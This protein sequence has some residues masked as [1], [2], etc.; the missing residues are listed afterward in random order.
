MCA[1][2]CA[3]PTLGHR[4]LS[5]FLA[6]RPCAYQDRTLGV[7][8]LLSSLTLIAW[9]IRLQFQKHGRQITLINR[10]KIAR[11]LQGEDNEDARSRSRSS[12]MQ[13]AS[14]M[15]D[16]ERRHT[17]RQ[18]SDLESSLKRAE[19]QEHTHTENDEL[20]DKRDFQEMWAESTETQHA[21]VGMIFDWFKH[22]LTLPA[23]LWFTLCLY[24][25]SLCSS[26][27]P[28]HVCSL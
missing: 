12:S 10:L 26:G 6:Y 24:L 25:H 20:F 9:A 19:E 4:I 3:V 8:L 17:F 13:R 14:I 15:L 11:D 27:Q 1:G 2:V 16:A 18:K 28:G 22:N 23:S 5:G 7:V 21:L